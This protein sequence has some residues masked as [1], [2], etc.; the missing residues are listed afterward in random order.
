MVILLK[1][2]DMMKNGRHQRKGDSAGKV[3]CDQNGWRSRLQFKI[4]R[5]GEAQLCGPEE[6]M[7]PSDSIP[8]SL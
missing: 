3:N 5:L 8:T 4:R 7:F 6:D 1:L 2:G